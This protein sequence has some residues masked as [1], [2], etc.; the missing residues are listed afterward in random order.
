MHQCQLL[1]MSI[2]Q[3]SDS[4]LPIFLQS[5]LINHL[6]LYFQPVILGDPCH[7]FSVYLLLRVRKNVQPLLSG[8]TFIYRWPVI[9]LQNASLINVIFSVSSFA[10][11][12][13]ISS[14]STLL[15]LRRA[16]VWFIVYRFINPA[17]CCSLCFRCAKFQKDLS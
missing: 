13:Q 17:F 12:L 5:S 3:A 15:A 16:L 9:T 11:I 10:E 6:A 2:A 14:C 4:I 8:L 7:Q 1:H